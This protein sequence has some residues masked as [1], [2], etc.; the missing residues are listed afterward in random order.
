MT[1]LESGEAVDEIKK[2]YENTANYVKAR[3]GEGVGGF[4]HKIAAKC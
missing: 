2:H 1:S 4:W 3:K